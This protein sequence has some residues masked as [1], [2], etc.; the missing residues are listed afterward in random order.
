M[1]EDNEQNMHTYDN[2]STMREPG[3]ELFGWLWGQDVLTEILLLIFLLTLNDVTSTMVIYVVRH[4]TPG[5]GGG[6]S[7]EVWDRETMFS[8]LAK[9]SI[10]GQVSGLP[11][12]RCVFSRFQL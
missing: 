3:D 10:R 11:R 12:R 2:L 8:Q 9:R 4:L 1:N 7:D 6:A 5:G